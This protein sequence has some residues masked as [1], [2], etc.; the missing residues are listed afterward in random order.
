VSSIQTVKEVLSGEICGM[1]QDM[2]RG[3]SSDG[4]VEGCVLISPNYF[5]GRDVKKACEELAE[6][7]RV[8]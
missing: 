2:A 5:S 6:E 4:A 1:L 8:K 7:F 3:V